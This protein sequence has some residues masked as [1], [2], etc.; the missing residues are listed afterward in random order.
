MS[1]WSSVRG[2]ATVYEYVDHYGEVHGKELD[3]DVATVC[4]DEERIRFCI[5]DYRFLMTLNQLRDFKSLLSSA[6]ASIAYWNSK[7]GREEQDR[8]MELLELLGH[9]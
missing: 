9:E 5:G 2:G 6:E 4:G 8:S 1:I 3:V 7:E